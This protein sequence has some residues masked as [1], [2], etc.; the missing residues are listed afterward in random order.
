M[1]PID[2]DFASGARLGTERDLAAALALSVSAVRKLRARGAVP[3]VKL[4]AS[5]RYHL[6]TV[7]AKLK[8]NSELLS[9][10]VPIIQ[11]RRVV[12]HKQPRKGAT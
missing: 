9:P 2:P 12:R 1:Q 10:P 3:A 8:V 4:G 6:P 5:V 7:K 11:R